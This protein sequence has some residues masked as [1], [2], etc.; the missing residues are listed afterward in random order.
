MN[1]R[2]RN[3]RATVDGRIQIDSDR[4][5]LVATA[6]VCVL[7]LL[8]ALSPAAAS[9][10]RD[11]NK[12]PRLVVQITVDAL[13]GDLPRRFAHMLGDGG[14]RYLM[15]Q[16]IDFTNAHYEHAITETIVGHVSLATGTTPSAHGMV[17]NV[18]FDR[19]LGRLVYNIE[20][21]DY[22]LLSSDSDVD[23]STEIDPTQKAAGVEGRSP[24]TILSTTFSDELAA[25]YAGQAKIFGIS[26]KD[27]GAVSLAGQ[28]GKAFWFSKANGEFVTSNYY[29]DAY[30]Q[31]VVDWNATKPAQDYAGGSWELMHE[32]AAYQFGDADDRDYETDFPGFGRTFPHPFG[33]GDDKYFTTRLTMSPVGDQLTLDFA[34]QL[35][36]N[37]KLGA[38]DIPDYL[39]VSF[40]S[41][42]YVGHV[43]GASSLESEDNIAYLDRTL[44]ELFRY[45]D[46]KVGLQHTLIVLSADHGQPEVPG[47]LETLGNHSAHYVDIVGLNK[48]LEIIATALEKRFG[49]G[50]ELVK[51]FFQPYL[52][53]DR[54]LIRSK[55]LDQ[56]EVEAV[57]VEEIAKFP[58]VSSVISSS[59]L[60]SGA[61]PDTELIHRVTNNFHPR[62]SGDI[63]V[64]F[65]PN[66]YVN[67]F[68]GLVVAATHGS[69]WR[70]D[71]FVPVMFAGAGLQPATVAR[72]VTPYDIAPTLANYLGV[73]QPSAASGVPL[74]EVVGD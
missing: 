2:A 38:D 53:L 71:A 19:A 63:F 37:E 41:T 29:Y 66:I 14:F 49:L 26:I 72:A 74:V 40:S 60:S 10:E 54:E 70:Y 39:A 67:D 33:A 23:K 24:R 7:L 1:L 47:Y 32:P 31:W 69:P 62:R 56:A 8:Q 21:A 17:G 27:R 50:E 42:D 11:A 13:R 58:G 4:Y 46:E 16:G 52:Y 55:G 57:F 59:G 22:H 9:D 64:V 45:I 51:E 43:F 68:G 6:T 15:E 3:L 34:K 36:D 48:M 73:N 28:A 25:H 35:I 61:V 65:E 5:R 30:P 18:W 44:A 12:A 20:D